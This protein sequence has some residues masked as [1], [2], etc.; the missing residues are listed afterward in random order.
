M[1][2]PLAVVAMVL[3]ALAWLA[4]IHAQNAPLAVLASNGIRAVMEDLAPQ[5]ERATGRKVARTYDLAANLK[6]RIEGGEAFDVAVVTPQVAD[7]LIKSGKLAAATRTT[8]ARSSLAVAIR[9]GA[10]KPDISTSDAFKRVL[11]EAKGV[12]YARE[13]ASGTA[14]LQAAEKL[15]IADRVRK[16]P[17]ASGEAVGAGVV[18]GTA[19]YG[20]LPVS[21]ILPV[22]GAEVLGPF[23]P[24]LRSYVTMVG[25]VSAA[26][27]N[28]AAAKSLIDFM[29]SPSATP[30]VTRHGMERSTP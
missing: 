1:K 20:I 2:I 25:G 30:A 4:P 3:G 29:M 11:L 12:A 26:S 5:F 6:R 13:G 9:S 18:N 8:I 15:G 16:M 10:S 27:A 23:P 19:E 28:A 14:F 24:D 17:V 22:Q 21:E 7:D